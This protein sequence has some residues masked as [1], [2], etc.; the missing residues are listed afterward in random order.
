MK[1]RL[2]QTLYVLDSM[3][4]TSQQS[5]PLHSIDA[6]AKAITTLVFL[7]AMLTVPLRNL[8]DLILFFIYPILLSSMSGVGYGRVFSR[9]L[10][11]IPFVAL[12]GIFNPILDRTAVFN[13]GG[14]VV[15]SGWITFLSIV[16]RGILS[17]EAVLILLYTTGFYRLCRGLQ[18]LG[19][20]SLFTSQLLFVYR[21]TYTLLQEALSMNRAREARSFGNSAHSMRQW[22]IFIGQLLLRTIERAERINRAMLSRGFDGTIHIIV[23]ARWRI[24]DTMFCLIWAIVLS[25]LR[26][27]HPIERLSSIITL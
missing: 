1:N 21:Y 26:L 8:S 19:I 16:I 3:E 20:P 18:R 23:E 12:I 22:G 25:A 13:V 10:I 27:L 5:S 15:T 11:V 14:V 2:E 7:V 24:G 9:S 17:V 4:R 6:R